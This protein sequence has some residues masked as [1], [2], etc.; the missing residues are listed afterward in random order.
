MSVALYYKSKLELSVKLKYLSLLSR[1]RAYKKKSLF[2][3]VIF[4]ERILQI[5][6]STD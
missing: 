1:I 6:Y 4:V 3:N 2:E 5:I